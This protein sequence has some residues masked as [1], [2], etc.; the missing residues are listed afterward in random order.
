MA[1]TYQ[2]LEKAEQV[3]LLAE[4]LYLALAAR[5]DGEPKSIFRRLAAEE[6]QHATRIRLLSARY[7]QDKKLVATLA[8]DT[9]L[10]DRLLLEAG[11][12]L[13]AA[14]GGAWDGAPEAAL[15]SAAALERRFCQVHA[16]VLSQAGHPELRAFFDQ[17]A[18]QDRA[19]LELLG[20]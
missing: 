12:A 1:S 16:Q 4:Q 8:A 6:A 20:P 11:E 10:L 9:A 17:L 7:R 13:A 19:H 18:A 15:E 3:E 14:K 2:L 5:F